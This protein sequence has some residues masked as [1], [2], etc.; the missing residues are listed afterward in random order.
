M[1]GPLKLFF[2]IIINRVIKL[3]IKMYLMP[4]KSVKNAKQLIMNNKWSQEEDYRYK[5]TLAHWLNTALSHYQIFS[6]M[7]CVLSAVFISLLQNHWMFLSSH[8]WNDQ[9]NDVRGEYL[10]L[11]FKGLW[12]S[13]VLFSF[14]SSLWV[15][16]CDSL[17]PRLLLDH[18]P[19]PSPQHGV[20]DLTDSGFSHLKA[21]CF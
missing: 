16:L 3:Y 14:P 17:M 6:F 1:I 18:Y 9:K 13:W 19:N 21:A 5:K 8:Q 4:N 15:P 12:E 10:L 7:L 2:F 20:S 11:P